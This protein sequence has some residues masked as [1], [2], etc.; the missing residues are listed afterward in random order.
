MRNMILFGNLEVVTD[1]SLKDRLWN[2]AFLEYY[3]NGKNDELYGVLKFIPLG[4]KYYV[5]ESGDSQVKNE[6]KF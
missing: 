1:K 2:D 4:Y 6:G 5:Y 3:K